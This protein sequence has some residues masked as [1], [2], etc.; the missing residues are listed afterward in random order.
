VSTA[1][2]IVTID[3]VPRP[4]VVVDTDGDRTLVRFRDAGGYR[5][6]WVPS[7]QALP[8]EA[9]G[10]RPPYLKLV[11]L[12]VLA[13]VGLLLVLYPGSDKP[14]SET[15]AR[16]STSATPTVTPTATAAP[17][18][19]PTTAAVT[20]V[21]AVVL[22]DSFSAGKGNPDGTPTA[23][24]L[25]AKALHW[26]ATVQAAKGSGFTTS[27]A[28]VA[29]R[30][31]A[32]TTAPTV[33]VLQAGA[34]DTAASPEALTTAAGAVLDT[35]RRRF[36]TTRVVLVGPFAMEQ[37]ADGQ[38]VRVDRTLAAVAKAHQ[39]AYV[40]PITS[41]W[42]TTANAGDLTASTGF[43]PNAQG[44]AYLAEQLEAALAKVS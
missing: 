9:P 40:D 4:A 8:V 30:L 34:S 14:L 35:A 24:E 21:Q 39:V 5:Q 26:T 37:P 2:V 7:S 31:A 23:L 42:I 28:S 17:T 18:A 1:E 16:P 12:G 10:G 43:Y 44:H 32:I 3:G 22:G 29:S 6:E 19:T 20:A 15:G 38:L 27:S 33:L 41:G 13:A 11:G 36:P 25:A